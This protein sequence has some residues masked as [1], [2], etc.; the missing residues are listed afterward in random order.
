MSIRRRS[1]FAALLGVNA[2]KA[3]TLWSSEARLIMDGVE[4]RWFHDRKPLN[5]QC[6]V[7]GTMAPAYINKFRCCPGGACYPEDPPCQQI[8]LIRCTRC[9]AAFWQDETINRP[10][11]GAQAKEKHE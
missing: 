2:A 10:A 9:S 11:T 6:P 8:N 1:F 4:L 3:Q 7:C 5:N